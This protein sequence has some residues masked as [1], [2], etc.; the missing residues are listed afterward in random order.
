[1]TQQRLYESVVLL[2]RAALDKPRSLAQKSSE[3][4]QAADLVLLKYETWLKS[5]LKVVFYQAI[6]DRLNHSGRLVLTSEIK[7]IKANA[8]YVTD[9]TSPSK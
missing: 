1:M 7:E 6:R 8:T 2:D 9:L 3:P 5:G 4:Q